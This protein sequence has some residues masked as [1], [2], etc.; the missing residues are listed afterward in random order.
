MRIP[1][2]SARLDQQHVNN[3]IRDLVIICLIIFL[4]VIATKTG[5]IHQLVLIIDSWQLL[6]I[7]IAGML[8]TSMFTAV[9]ATV[10]LAESA[11]IYPVWLVALLGATGAMLGDFFIYRFV[12][13][14]LVADLQALLQMGPKVRWPKIFHSRLFRWLL[15]FIGAL[16]I[17]SPLPDELGVAILGISKAPRIIFL[18]I[19]FSFN[20]IGIAAISW[21]ARA[22]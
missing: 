9:P 17:A 11:L 4:T 1:Y 18:M 20:F 5:I 15:P 21:I 13:D 8:F 19:A 2:F 3:I 10:L 6:G 12:K 22:L 7:F 16:I 14:S